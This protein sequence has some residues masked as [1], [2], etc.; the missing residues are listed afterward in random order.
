[1]YSVL[2]AKLLINSVVEIN[3]ENSK[4]TNNIRPIVLTMKGSTLS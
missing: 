1:M 2:K 4:L 3:K